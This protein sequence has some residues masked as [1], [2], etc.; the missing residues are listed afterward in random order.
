MFRKYVYLSVV[1][2]GGSS[3]HHIRVTSSLPLSV[4]HKY[5]F[6]YY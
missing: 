5:I 2:L 4:L 3:K 1:L 6:L